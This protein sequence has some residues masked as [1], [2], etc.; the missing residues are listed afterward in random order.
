MLFRSTRDTGLG[1]YTAELPVAGLGAGETVQFTFF[2]L[3][4][5]SWE[6]VDYEVQLID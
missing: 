2:W 6:G 5:G 3:D 4:G 1:A